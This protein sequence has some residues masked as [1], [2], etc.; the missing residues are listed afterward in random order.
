MENRVRTEVPPL[1]FIDSVKVKLKLKQVEPIVTKS[2]FT[3]KW[4]VADLKYITCIGEVRNENGKTYN[5]RCALFSSPDN[6]WI[7]VKGRFKE[8]K[9]LID[10]RFENRYNSIGYGR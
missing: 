10:S 6:S 4:Y 1:S 3:N 7:T 8:V 2:V 9:A 5:T